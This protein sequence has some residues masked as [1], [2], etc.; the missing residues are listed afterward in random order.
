MTIVATS[1]FTISDDV[2]A[3]KDSIFITGS[4][5][6]FNFVDN[7]LSPSSQTI[8]LFAV[9]EL[10]TPVRWR[11]LEGVP[12][13]TD[14]DM[15]EICPLLC[16]LV[17]SSEGT[18][19][20]LKSEDFG[21]NR[22]YVT[23]IAETDSG[24]SEFL[25]F[26]RNNIAKT[27]SLIDD[28]LLGQTAQWNSVTG[29][30]KPINDAGRVLDTRSVNNPP[31]AY[32]VGNI[33]EFKTC[34][35]VGISTT[36]LY[37]VVETIKGWSDSSGGDATQWAY[38][39]S[40]EVW[41]RSAGNSATSWGAW[42]RDIDRSN[43]T[44]DLD[45]NKTFIDSLGKLQGVSSGAGTSVSNEVALAWLAGSDSLVPDYMIADRDRWLPHSGSYANNATN[46][47][48]ITDG[49]VGPTA[50]R[51][52]AGELSWHYNR[53][54]VPLVADHVYRFEAYM[55]MSADNVGLWAFTRLNFGPTGAAASQSYGYHSIT[56]PGTG[57]TLRTFELTASAVNALIASGVTSIQP[58]FANYNSSVGWGEIQ[59][60][61]FY[62]A[63]NDVAIEA[64]ATAAAAAVTSAAT[65]NSLLADISS[66]SK[67]TPIEKQA[68]RKEWDV[69][70]AEKGG[71]VAS[72]TALSITTETAAYSSKFTALA[73]YLNAG[74][75]WVSG[76]PSWISDAALSTTT[77]VVGA[78]FRTSFK[79]YYDAR[80]VLLNKI[81][82]VAAT[83]A[84]WASV[85]GTG[86]PADNANNTSVDSSGNI[87]GV[88]SGAGTSVANNVDSVIRNPGGGVFT[89]TTAT[90]TGAIKIT[91]P[92]SW[93]STMLK[94]H[95]DIFEYLAGYSCSL[96]ISGY[97]YAQSTKGWH[98]TSAR[99]IGESNTEYPVRFGHDGA[100]C[101]VWIGEPTDTWS[102]PQIRIKEVFC[103]FNYFSKDAWSNGWS[104]SFDTSAF[105][106][107]TTPNGAGQ[108]NAIITDSLP[109]ANWEKISGS[110][111][112]QNNATRNVY[113]GDWASGTVY[114]VGDAVMHGGYGWSCITA[115]TSAA[116]TTPP[117]YPT[118]S[119]ANWTLAAI[120]GTDAK[121][122]RV[123][124]DAQTVKVA[125]NGTLTPATVNL[126]AF[127]Q[128]LSGS[129]TFSVHS[130][131]V[132][133][134]GS[135]STRAIATSS[136]TTDTATIKV[137]WDGVEDYI[138]IAKL[139][140]GTNAITVLVSNESHSL[141]AAVDGTVSS[142]TGCGTTV[143][144]FEGS[145]ALTA[146]STATTSAF[147]VGTITQN[148][149]ST[150]TV[151][152]VSYA[153]TTATIADH[154]AM[155]AVANVVML[156]LPI[157]V[158]RSDGT[159]IVIN[160]TQ[161]ITKSK[162][163]ATG[164]TGAMG[165]NGLNF[166]NAKSLYNDMTFQNGTNTVAVYNNGT[167]GLVTITRE[168]KQSD[169]PFAESSYNLKISNTGAV[170]PGI[171]GFYHN[172]TSRAS[173]VF[174]QRIIAKIPVGYTIEQASNAIGDGA[175]HTWL[176]SQAGTGKFQEYLLI[177]RCGA[178]GTFSGSGHIY[179]N[180]AA[181]SPGAPVNWYV[182]FAAVY[183]FTAVN[184]SSITM[185][186][187]NESHTIPTDSAGANGVFT[188][189]ETT[190]AIYDGVINDTANWTIT[191]TPTNVTGSYTSATK[192][193]TVTGMSSDVGYVDISA[194]RTGFPT[195]S[196][197]MTIS[198][199][200]AGSNATAKYIQLFATGQVFTYRDGVASPSSQ[201]ITFTA[202]PSNLS[203][204]ASFTTSPAV[205]LSGTGNERTM[206]I[207]DFGSNTQVVVTV[208]Q[209]GV[210]DKMT[211]IRLNQSTASAYA[212]ADLD[213][214]FDPSFDKQVA[215]GVYWEGVSGPGRA[216][217]A[218]GNGEGVS[219]PGLKLYGTGVTNQVYTPLANRI[220]IK[221]GEVLFVR[222]RV[223]VDAAFN[224]GIALYAQQY[225]SSGT[226]TAQVNSA[227]VTTSTVKSAWITVDRTL[228]VTDATVASIRL[229]LLTSTTA[230]A[231]FVKIDKISVF[232]QE[233]GAT[234]GATIGTN[235]N[236]QIT[237]ANSATF[238]AN[239][240][241]QNAQIANVIQSTN[242]SA[243]VAGWKIDKAGNIELNAAVF[244]GTIDVKS[245]ASGARLEIKNDVIKVYDAN[246]TLRVKLGNLSA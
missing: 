32:S 46:Y 96:E 124:A 45:A 128:G 117:T 71:I 213:L 186:L 35:V 53:V 135:G 30:G 158:Y 235:L 90:F 177:R 18:F 52:N 225:D 50:F 56:A 143:Q 60:F 121:V 17:S 137:V 27:S 145:T 237:S 185:L 175:T 70:A 26:R 126:T 153:G 113:R 190:V 65:A 76:V 210:S 160:K 203:G 215:G 83:T 164:A 189:C 199:S 240:A 220:S 3:A 205:T 140:E 180:G 183:D 104:I 181:G 86:K 162:T 134:T 139:K 42:V 202:I 169:S 94:I 171:G 241:I 142:Y 72:A 69:I 148:P 233:P 55:R 174:V 51:R 15:M 16:G 246:G 208:T 209:D 8:G 236:G 7:A 157:T 155:S 138:S 48:T 73:N 228:T 107:A 75:T 1:Q 149:T 25:V 226:Y 238:I 188:G 93:T 74:T 211:I 196:K 106:L 87:Q 4:S 206:S 5:N 200:K 105:V 165:P 24:A 132:T 156:T 85:T 108:Y 221:N 131:T 79:E 95:V 223:Y 216:E 102:F 187:S 82:A 207:A 193:Y 62:D 173:A 167:A 127:G 9:T 194:T 21:T 112:P 212:N 198:K 120:K 57:W 204:S 6:Y 166:A 44:G 191:A 78:A 195:L 125:Q 234:V 242:F 14:K 66:D 136:L 89:T 84:S 28:A 179:L 197:R 227:L 133:L 232:R 201:T 244:R 147:R 67:L 2:T 150:I 176:T 81:A 229:S 222:A 178:T 119:N 101:C 168:A 122:V 219:A 214:I 109:G 161:T 80:Q 98:N 59:G 29:A 118:T 154:S 239:G 40:G 231:G 163:G 91:L 111:K 146:S 129:P 130:G 152:A 49:K 97:T 61:R 218:V 33:R 12:I 63:T 245:A 43:Y 13:Y 47:V 64:A 37:C 36:A 217:I 184:T 230:T 224:G 103:G 23:V 10:R 19:A 68:V 100:K 22:D 77:D 88:S 41:K 11:T 192:T 39:S 144:V 38:V 31:S 182:A 92:Q 99:V 170:A 151:G 110:N 243:G 115:H 123:T 172:I 114:A 116:G 58:G 141:P 54:K 20:Y 159:S 34:S